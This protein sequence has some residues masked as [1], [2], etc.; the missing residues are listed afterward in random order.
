MNNAVD[1]GKTDEEASCP[2]ELGSHG[3]MG[4]PNPKAGEK[5]NITQLQIQKCENSLPSPSAAK[6]ESEE[7]MDYPSHVDMCRMFRLPE[8]S[9]APRW[10]PYAVQR[11]VGACQVEQ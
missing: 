10:T 9:P 4:L 11:T 3:E 5:V 6:V 7:K 1:A 8:T 2:S